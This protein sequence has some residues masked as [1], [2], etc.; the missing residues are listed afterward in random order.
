[1]ALSACTSDIPLWKVSSCCAVARR[2]A[3]AAPS[4]Q[5]PPFRLPGLTATGEVVAPLQN[6]VS[7]YTEVTSGIGA[8]G[9]ELADIVSAIRPAQP[10]PVPAIWVAFC[11]SSCWSGCEN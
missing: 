4:E 8:P 9:L 1:M 10:V 11:H 7:P 5:L 6:S 2:P 3:Q